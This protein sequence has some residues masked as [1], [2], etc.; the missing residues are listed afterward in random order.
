M[1]PSA[2]GF[3]VTPILP[4]EASFLAL[5][6][7]FSSLDALIPS[8]MDPNRL[9]SLGDPATGSG[10]FLR[11]I[12]FV[13]D[14]L[15]LFLLL[16]DTKGW[17][18]KILVLGLSTAFTFMHSITKSLAVS[19]RHS[20]SG[21]GPV[22]FPIARSKAGM[23]LW[24]STH[25]AFPVIISITVQPTAHT[26]AGK[27][28]G[29]CFTTSGAMKAGVPCNDV[30]APA[31]LKI[32]LRDSLDFFG[33][34]IPIHAEIP[35]AGFSSSS[36]GLPRRLLTPKSAIFTRPSF[37]HRQLAAL[38]SRCAIPCPWR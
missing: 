13:F 14:S 30:L 11:S 31:P 17:S 16:A 26:S 25:G 20:T 12:F 36:I 4:T 22:V 28:E 18:S 9:I 32:S 8:F 7:L 27:P 37:V 24:C 10:S 35:V 3:P 15:R 2:E 5:S 34:P 38:M 21:G 23:L 19:G 33:L 29:S 1:L 6:F